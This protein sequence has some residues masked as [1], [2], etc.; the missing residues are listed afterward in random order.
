MLLDQVAVRPLPGGGPLPDRGGGWG[1]SRWLVFRRR[2]LSVQLS[3]LSL[4]LAN[5][6]LATPPS[7]LAKVQ[8][9]GACED[10]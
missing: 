6:G 8:I 7:C 10:D 5:P 4:S 2:C 1:G 9:Q 3:V